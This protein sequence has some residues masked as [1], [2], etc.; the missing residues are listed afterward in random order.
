MQHIDIAP[1]L[2]EALQI[3]GC[4]EQ[5][6]GDFDSHSTIELELENL[7]SIKIALT[8][9]G[10][11]LWSTLIE[12]SDVLLTYKSTDLLQFLMQGCQYARTH[13]M[14]LDQVDGMLELRVLL[15]DDAFID[16][17]AFA[18]TIDAYLS[19]MTSLHELVRL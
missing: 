14:Q 9:S 4:D 3:S 18:E 10:L 2:L 8:E 15:A 17:S 5:Q 7:P 1:L 11:W 19:A 12:S 6:I 13:Q 16:A